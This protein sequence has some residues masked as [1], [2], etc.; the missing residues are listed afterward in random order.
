MTIRR[1]ERERPAQGQIRGDG[2]AGPS[3]LVL[4]RDLEAASLRVEQSKSQHQIDES[5]RQPALDKAT[6]VNIALTQ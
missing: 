1:E 2:E 4:G 6:G 5:V 3:V